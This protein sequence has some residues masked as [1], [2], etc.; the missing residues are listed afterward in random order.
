MK[1]DTWKSAV[2]EHQWDQQHQVHW[3]GMRVLDRAARPIQL[4]VKETFLIERTPTYTRLD[5]NGGKS[6][7]TAGSLP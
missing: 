1:G 6:Y 2:A 4:K 5:R 3:D 7:R